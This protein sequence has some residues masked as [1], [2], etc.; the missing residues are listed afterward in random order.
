MMKVKIIKGKHWYI[1]KVGQV[2]EVNNRENE[3]VYRLIDGNNKYF[4]IFKE[5]AEIIDDGKECNNCEYY[6]SD[7]L[8]SNC[9][10]GGFLDCPDN[11]FKNWKEKIEEEKGCRTCNRGI[12]EIGDPICMDIEC[13]MGTWN[14]WEPIKKEIDKTCSSCKHAYG[15]SDCNYIMVCENSSHWDLKS[16]KNNKEQIIPGVGKESETTVN[17]QGGKQS[18]LIY[19]FDAIDPQAMFAIAKVL[20][21]GREKYGYDENWR[22][23]SPNDHYNHLLTHLNAWKSG[24]KTDEHLAHGLCR[25]MMLYATT[26]ELR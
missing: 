18:K 25:M 13:V 9:Y 17:N 20:Q 4:P 24:D 2:F 15:L 21:E 12:R 14:K 23:I 1:D 8:K 16:K 11:N 10:V 7:D 5:D 22:K 26:E 3:G 6:S 19:A